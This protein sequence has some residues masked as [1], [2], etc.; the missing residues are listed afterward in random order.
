[1]EPPP[2]QHFSRAALCPSRFACTVLTVLLDA[3]PQLTPWAAM[4]TPFQASSH[5][6]GAEDQQWRMSQPPDPHFP[7]VTLPPSHFAL[8]GVT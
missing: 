5:Q 7:H 8:H 4:A 3:T 6:T 1:M 2:S